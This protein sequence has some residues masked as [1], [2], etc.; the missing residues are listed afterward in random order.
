MGGIG[1]DAGQSGDLNLDAGFFPDLA[2]HR[3]R[4]G[5]ADLLRS[6][7][8]CPQPVVGPLDQEDLAAVVADD[9]ADSDYQAVGLGRVRVGVVVRLWA[10]LLATTRT[11]R[12]PPTR[13]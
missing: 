3:V 6:A 11:E 2:A 13:R 10:P 7:G 1:V 8:Q 9:S 12:R 5:L 4:D